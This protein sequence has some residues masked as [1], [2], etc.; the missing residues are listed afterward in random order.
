MHLTTVDNL[1]RPNCPETGPRLDVTCTPLFLIRPP[2]SFFFL[3]LPWPV[4]PVRGVFTSLPTI[5]IVLL[6]SVY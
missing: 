1:F 5:V 2:P 6:L 4:M 3:L